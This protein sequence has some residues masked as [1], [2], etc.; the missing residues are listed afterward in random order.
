VHEFFFSRESDASR[1]LLFNSSEEL[2]SD[3]LVVLTGVTALDVKRF[4]TILHP[5]CVPPPPTGVHSLILLISYRRYSE[6]PFQTAAE[7]IS[8][9]RLATDWDFKAIRELAINKLGTITSHVDRIELGHFY[10]TK[11]WLPDAYTDI[12]ERHEPLTDAECEQLGARHALR[13]MRVRE[14]IQNF[15]LAHSDV[16]RRYI[17]DRLCGDG[18]GDPSLEVSLLD[19]AAFP[20]ISTDM[21][22]VAGPTAKKRSFKCQ[23]VLQLM[24]I[25]CLLFLP[26]LALHTTSVI[27]QPELPSPS[28]FSLSM[29]TVNAE[30]IQ[31]Y[32]NVTA[33]GHHRLHPV[34]TYLYSNY[35]F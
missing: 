14:K 20:A 7:W 24:F 28:T 3:R 22:P 9:L 26:L 1:A 10:D 2:G 25:A 11:D 4:L 6:R 35:R 27:L 29:A 18:D 13:I 23:L 31:L 30:V 15:N 21:D 16:R 33:Y 12:C 17:V 19:A 34:I 32:N 8:V 5:P